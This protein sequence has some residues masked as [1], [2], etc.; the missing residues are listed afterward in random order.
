M[1]RIIELSRKAFFAKH[2]E[3]GGKKFWYLPLI[4]MF[5]CGDKIYERKDAI[6]FFPGSRDKLIKHEEGHINGLGH[7]WHG[8]MAWHSLER[9]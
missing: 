8:V 4:R 6:Y 1:T 5:K 3:L 2:K 9:M 7:T